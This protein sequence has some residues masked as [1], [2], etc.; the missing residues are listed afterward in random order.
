MFI[1]LEETSIQLLCAADYDILWRRNMSTKN[2]RR[3]NQLTS[4]QT[5]M[6]RSMLNSGRKINT[7]VKERTT[8]W[9]YIQNTRERNWFRSSHASRF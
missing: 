4:A 1:I 8:H 9:H 2:K 7:R 5:N 3:A 6:E